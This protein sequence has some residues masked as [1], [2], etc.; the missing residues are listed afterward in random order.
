MYKRILKH[1]LVLVLSLAPARKPHFLSLIIV[2]TEF[3]NF[4]RVREPTDFIR[5]FRFSS[6]FASFGLKAL[7]H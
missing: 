2:L 3:L 4:I 5:Y 7:T 6:D 1:R